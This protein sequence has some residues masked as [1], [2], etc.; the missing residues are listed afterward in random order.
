MYRQVQDDSLG[1]RPIIYG[2]A[3]QTA[4]VR[5]V[6]ATH[7]L[8]I[9]RDGRAVLVPSDYGLLDS[10]E[11]GTSHRHAP[12]L[13]LWIGVSYACRC[14]TTIRQQ[15][16]IT[17]NKV[18]TSGPPLSDLV[19][20]PW[21]YANELLVELAVLALPSNE[22]V[23]I[24]CWMHQYYVPISQCCGGD[25][26]FCLT[27]ASRIAWKSRNKSPIMPMAEPAL[28][29]A[30]SVAGLLDMSYFSGFLGLT[31]HRMSLPSRSTGSLSRVLVFIFAAAVAFRVCA[32]SGHRCERTMRKERV[33]MK[34][35][36]V[37]KRRVGASTGRKT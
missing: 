18:C 11:V 29:K 13:E 10:V 6:E 5:V 8:R 3:Q 9:G 2:G 7:G 35:W 36:S 17:C 20:H 28:T 19:N 34:E 31:V 22:I 16:H 33:T 21:D 24:V 14:T 25:C 23:R 27:P 32:C 26:S 1:V 12:I 37:Q 4:A 15:T 30:A